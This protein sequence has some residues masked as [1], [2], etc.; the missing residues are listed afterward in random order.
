MKK[1]ILLTALA[2]LA[3]TNAAKSDLFVNEYRFIINQKVPRIYDNNTSQGYRK[4][5]AQRIKGTLYIVYDMNPE[6]I[7]LPR[8]FVKDLVNRTH[9]LA[10]DQYVTYKVTVN[11]KGAGPGP[12]TRVNVIGDN[13]TEVFSTPSIVCYMDAEPS[14]NKGEDDEDNSLLI[15][16]AG[17]GISSNRKIWVH[18]QNDDQSTVIEYPSKKVIRKVNGYNAGSLGCGCMAYGHKSPTRVSSWFDHSG[19]VDD[20][21]ATLGM[22][23]IQYSSSYIVPE[24]EFPYDE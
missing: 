21:A 7:R 9:R 4:Y 14:Y 8:I 18:V 6:S 3:F 1:S 17:Y 23:C 16:L 22:W 5:Q 10:N 20:V 19:R 2:A 24:S 11:N 12:L 15:T 13:E